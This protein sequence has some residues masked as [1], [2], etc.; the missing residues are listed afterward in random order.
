MKEDYQK[1]LKKLTLSFRL[2][3]VLFNGQ[4]YKKKSGLELVT[5]LSSGYKTSLEKIIRYVSVFLTQTISHLQ[6][7][8]NGKVI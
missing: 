1:T 6:K 4:H 7:N 5:S 3:S 8:A 2:N